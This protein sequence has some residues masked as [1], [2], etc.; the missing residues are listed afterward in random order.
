MIKHL[1]RIFFATA[2]LLAAGAYE[3]RAEYRSFRSR[4]A[5]ERPDVEET[6]SALLEKGSAAEE[7]EEWRAAVRLYRRLVERFPESELAPEAQ[8]RYGYALERS[9]RLHPAFRAYQELLRRYPGK[10]NLGLILER[11]LKIGRE[12]LEGRRR[13]FLFIRI[14][15]G[16]SLAEEIFQSIIDTAVFSDAAPEAQYNLGLIRMKQGRYEEAEVEFEKVLSRY[17]LSDKAPDAV[18]QL[19]LSSY[20][21]ALRAD[22]DQFFVQRAVRW[23]ET[24]LRRYPDHPRRDEAATKLADLVGRQAEKLY[25]VGRFYQRRRRWEGARI[26]YENIIRRF[27]DTSWARKARERLAA[28]D[29]EGR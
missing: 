6:P 26:Y 23:F 11:K 19:G 9:G 17:S 13:P 14:R 2:V 18:Y 20:Q 5:E 28:L 29:R 7:R 1:K 22:Y 4:P 21:R 12:Y 16:L 27:P 24:L 10:G 8:F 25:R 15:S 3:A